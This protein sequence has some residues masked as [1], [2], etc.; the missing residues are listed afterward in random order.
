MNIC[1]YLANQAESKHNGFG[2]IVRL[3]FAEEEK[4]NLHFSH[5][6]FVTS[7]KRAELVGFGDEHLID[8][9]EY[10][11]LN[12]RQVKHGEDHQARMTE[13]KPKLTDLEKD[14]AERDFW[15]S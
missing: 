7:R 2:E 3:I 14:L 15:N 13:L 9:A 8:V 5:E 1:E 11:I 6:R 4:G 10:A 12:H